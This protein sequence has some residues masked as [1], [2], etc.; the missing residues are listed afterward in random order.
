VVGCYEHDSEPSDPIGVG[1]YLY[2]LSDYQLL[3][4]DPAAWS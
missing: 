3:K 4:K 1:E 2:R